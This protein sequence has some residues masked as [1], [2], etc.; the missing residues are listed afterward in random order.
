MPIYV[1]IAVLN[2]DA[3][4]VE[5]FQKMSDPP[6]E[7]VIDIPEDQILSGSFAGVP[8][9]TEVERRP[10]APGGFRGLPTPKFYKRG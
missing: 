3:P 1:Y 7:R 6:F 9:E 4:E 5:V 2:E 8:D 10:S